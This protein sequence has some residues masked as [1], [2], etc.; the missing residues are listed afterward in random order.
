MIARTARRHR[1][2][3]RRAASAAGTLVPAYAL[4]A[5]ADAATPALKRDIPENPWYLRTLLSDGFDLDPRDPG[6]RPLW[7]AAAI[8][9]HL[10]RKAAEYHLGHIYTKCG[11]RGRQ[12]LRR[13]V[14]RWRQPSAV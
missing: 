3:C 4:T 13:F 2:R 6:A 11:L 9:E 7:L 14:E 5:C 10:R 12:E 1:S 8:G